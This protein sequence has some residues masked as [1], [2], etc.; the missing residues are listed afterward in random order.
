MHVRRAQKKYFPIQRA[1]GSDI[2][3]ILVVSRAFKIS[4]K[5]KI[6]QPFKA[7]PSHERMVSFVIFEKLLFNI[8][9]TSERTS[10][11]VL[12][13]DGESYMQT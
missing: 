1:P 12:Q 13:F 7:F 5:C 6:Q 11:T 3:M 2:V 9:A 10:C 4:E 8:A